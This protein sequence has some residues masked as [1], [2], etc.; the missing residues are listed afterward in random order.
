MGDYRPKI[1]RFGPFEVDLDQRLLFRAGDSVPLTPKAFETLAVLVERQGKVVDKAELL[2]LVWPDTFV[3]ENNL[4][5]NISALRKAFGDESYIETIPRRGYR[6]LAEV[7]NVPAA[8]TGQVG[9]E[10]VARPKFRSVWLWAAFAITMVALI[11]FYSVNKIPSAG[12]PHFRVDSLVVLPFVNMTANPED[13]YFSDGLTEELTNSVAHL[14][15]LRVV[16]RTTAFQFKGKARDIRL[17]ADQLHVNAVIEGSV[18]RQEKKLRV[19]VQLNDAQSGYHIWSQTYDRDAGNIFSIQEDIS[20]QVAHTIRP[21]GPVFRAAA[22]T[23][24]HSAYNLYLLG[25][26]HRSKP[27]GAS[28]RKAM[29]F[30][31]Q[32]IAQDAGYAAAYAGLAECYVKLAQ[33]NLMPSVEAG[34]AAQQSLD[35][36]LALDDNLAE[37]HTTQAMVFLLMD[38]NWEAAELQFRRALALNGNDAAAHHWFSHYFTAMGRVR[39]SLAESRKALELSPLD[40]QI[41]SH[42]VSNYVRA[43]DF[44]SA[45]KAGLETLELDPHSQLAYLFLMWAYEDTG[46]WDKAIDAS[47]RA[48]RAH[49]EASVLQAAV[50]A[51]GPRGYWR[52]NQAFQSQQANPD[53]FRLAVCHARLGQGEQ[54]LARLEQAFQKREPESIYVKSEPAFDWMHGD[55]RFMALTEAIKLP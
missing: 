36:A 53:N 45:I 21:N 42:L 47:Q 14:D 54:A 46:Q 34:A 5:Q 23:K 33:G 3:E 31:E 26:F 24:D 41:S 19:T 1:R 29:A 18:R 9:R 32:A 16:S 28:V 17:I 12:R 13:E 38:R 20:N 30:F 52:V 50:H 27:D 40:V 44:P 35:K 15:G 55:P 11:A 4:T 8:E 49:P 22:G 48:T 10:M 2:K 6:L 25:R 37:A 43:R 51:E 39:E 7:A